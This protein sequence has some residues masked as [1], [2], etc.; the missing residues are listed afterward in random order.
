MAAPIAVG[1]GV[2]RL[3]YFS[4]PLSCTKA[5]YSQAR[6]S[7]LSLFFKQHR[8]DYYRLLDVVSRDGDWEAWLD[9][10]LGG[11]EDTASNAVSTARR[12]VDLFRED[13]SNLDSVVWSIYDSIVCIRSIRMALS[14]RNKEAER[15]AR[16]V[17][18]ET[19]ET[20]TEAIMR[21]L[22][23]RLL[24]LSGRR[25]ATDL[26]EEILR[27]GSRCAALPDVDTRTADEI[28]GYD[29]NGVVR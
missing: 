8:E 17:A 1:E 11:V 10:F 13:S 27:I 20:I 3:E 16:E 9:F 28:L 12:L 4:S 7:T 25:T 22:E 6:C 21:S 26:A 14:I 18:R 29:E 2:N 19:G 23:E 15:L 5:A 24:R